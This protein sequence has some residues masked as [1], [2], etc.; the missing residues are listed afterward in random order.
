MG[1]L[2]FFSARGRLV[3]AGL[4]IAA[5]GTLSGADANAQDMDK[6]GRDLLA[7]QAEIRQIG[8]QIRAPQQLG[9]DRSDISERR[10]IAAQVAFGIG[11]YD[12][13]AI[14]LYDL[15]EKGPGSRSYDESVYYLAESLFQKRDYIGA[16]NYFTKLVDDIGSRSKFYQRSL[17]RLVE[18][19]LKIEGS[20]VEQYLAKLDQVPKSE[21]ESSV[22][23]VRGR[24]LY[25]KGEFQPAIASF[26]EVPRGTDYS[27][28]AQY[29][30]G[31]AQLAQGDLGDAATTYQSL[32]RT[33][34]K[35][36][37]DDRVI[38]LT[39]MALGRIFYERDQ[40][41]EALDQY[42]AISRK[43]D[44]FDDALYEIAWVYVS[45]Q[46]FEQ[47]LRALELLALAN[48]SSAK[49][50]D[51][52]VLE[53]NLR[54]RKAQRFEE[55]GQGNPAEQYARAM[56]VFEDTRDRYEQPLRDLE[57]IIAE[58][59]DPRTFVNQITG[60]NEDAFDVAVRLPDEAV[61][62]LREDPE[63]ERVVDLDQ[64]LISI[65]RDLAEATAN[66][67]RLEAAMNS[68]S[69][70]NI[71]PSLAEKRARLTEIREA[72]FRDRRELVAAENRLARKYASPQQKAELEQLA[73][74]REAIGRRL[75]ALPGAELSYSERVAQAR[76][77]YDELARESQQLSINIGNTEATL[78]ALDKYLLD[79]ERR[80]AP[81]EETVQYREAMR[82]LNGELEQLKGSMTSLQHDITIARD[83]AGVGDAQ[84]QQALS[85]QRDLNTVMEQ[86]QALAD[87]IRGQAGGGDSARLSQIDTLT[88]RITGA[89]GE[90]AGVD[91]SI[92]KVVD[93]ALAEV[94][95]AVSDEKRRIVTYREEMARYEREA[96]GVGGEVLSGTFGRVTKKFYNVLVR[97]DVGTTDVA[98]ANKERTEEDLKRLRLE[99]SKD[100][101]RLN[102]EFREILDERKRLEEESQTT[103]EGDG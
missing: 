39:H 88:G 51:V 77:R 10:L 59:P 71:F 24:Y 11:N 37:S 86:E 78:A 66:V 84:A 98:W 99:E 97:A 20:E 70:V 32:L 41:T 85:M 93:V 4:A 25:F 102:D 80:G 6:M 81:R 74:E 33:P 76:E 1:R 57:A 61:A 95:T 3:A 54:I 89:L 56:N 7:H 82:E 96:Q 9:R 64:D 94:R 12:D 48:A 100:K 75:A 79:A 52:R 30:T 91:A 72:L 29:F 67:E 31:A 19:S 40:A 47:A 34:P 69:S 27:I 103:Q 5:V 16:Q 2:P 35:A 14:L 49:L 8:Q 23:Y 46:K 22:P 90:L 73:R 18:L 15:V 21:L 83:Q 55:N 92:T 38:E 43:S 44:L 58:R 26:A 53:G 50:P 28:R 36:E 45:A 13:A 63:V 101:R 42:L 65:E 68:G 60:R 87:G 17:E 62:W